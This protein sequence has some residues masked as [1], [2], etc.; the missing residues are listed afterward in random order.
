MDHEISSSQLGHEQVGWDWLSIHLEDESELM[1]YILRDAAGN[2]DPFS[3]LAWIQPNGDLHHM[4]SSQFSWSSAGSW[5]SLETGALYP[6]D[7][8]LRGQRPDGTPFVFAV[9]PLL[10]QQELVGKLGGISYWEGACDVFENNQPIGEAYMEL[11]GYQKSLKD[12][13]R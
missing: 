13:L 12:D 7:V 8:T 1:V 6:I 5:T 10:R 3:T 11:T 9:K 4:D 2:P